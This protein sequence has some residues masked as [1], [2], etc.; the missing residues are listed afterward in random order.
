MG[1][2]T[3][4]IFI[5]VLAA[6]AVSGF[7]RGFVRSLIGFVG[8]IVALFAAIYYAASFRRWMLALLGNTAPQWMRDPV[9]SE[10]IAVLVLFAIFDALIHALGNVL[11]C[12]CRLPVLRQ[13]NWVAGGAFGL[14]KGFVIVLLLCALLQVSL[15]AKISEFSGQPVQKVASSRIY[16][17][18]SGNNPVYMLIQSDLFNEVGRNEYKE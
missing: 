10:I 6:S 11:N 13:L 4:I 17:S 2:A 3:D 18:L 16:R 12:V 7:R 1:I 9:W 5:V 15:P 14:C 8:G